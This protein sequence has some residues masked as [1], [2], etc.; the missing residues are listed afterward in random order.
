MALSRTK[1]ATRHLLL[2]SF[3]HTVLFSL[4]P[5]RQSYLGGLLQGFDGLQHDL[6]LAALV[7]LHHIAAASDTFLTHKHTWHLQG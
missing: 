6:Q 3:C 1:W 5:L 2:L 4:C 7:E